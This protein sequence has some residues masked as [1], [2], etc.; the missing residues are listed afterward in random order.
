MHKIVQ[1]KYVSKVIEK[2]MSTSPSVP[3]LQCLQTCLKEYGGTC[4]IFK[5]KIFN[6]CIA[7]VDKNDLA[8][9]SH[10]AKCLHFL[11]QSR[12]GSTDGNAHKKN[13]AEYHEKVLNTLKESFNCLL[14]TGESTSTGKSERLKLPEKAEVKKNMPQ[15]YMHQENFTRF[16]NICIL[17]NT[18]LIQPFPTAKSIL[19]DWMMS[20]LDK[21]IMIN[22]NQINKKDGDR[23]LPFVLN[24][25]I[26][27]CLLEVLKTVIKAVGRNI[28]VYSKDVCDLL[29]R[30][31]KSTNVP[32]DEFKV[33]DIS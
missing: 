7:S 15:M 24:I 9:S 4:G 11:Q 21:S 16:Q 33:K 10:S 27:K 8:L 5:N 3:A 32:Y 6:Y 31:L 28:I 12:G 20:F 26:H 2:I 19:L 13:W 14:Q 30:C 29:W 18:S 1:G 25:E 23:L 22:Q 17:L